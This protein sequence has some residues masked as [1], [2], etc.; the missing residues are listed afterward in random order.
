[1]KS[2]RYVY[3]IQSTQWYHV[4]S[5]RF[6]LPCTHGFAICTKYSLSLEVGPQCLQCSS[7]DILCF[8]ISRVSAFVALCSTLSENLPLLNMPLPQAA[9]HFHRAFND[10]VTLVLFM[11]AI[12]H[13]KDSDKFWRQFWTFID[14]D[15]STLSVS[16]LLQN[17]SLGGILL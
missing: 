1:M 2:C 11:P 5:T 7:T 15:C 8:G 10:L 12:L 13:H 17:V 4:S 16:A 3:T 6:I 9:L 14:Y